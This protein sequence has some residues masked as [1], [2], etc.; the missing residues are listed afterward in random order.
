MQNSLHVAR[1]HKQLTVIAKNDDPNLCFF[2]GVTTKTQMDTYVHAR[3]DT[4][5]F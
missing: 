5:P 3:I 2:M 4:Y 1:Y